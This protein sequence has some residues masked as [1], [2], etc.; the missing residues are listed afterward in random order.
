M[1]LYF[2][3]IKT[4]PFKLSLTLLL[5]GASL[6]GFAQNRTT[7]QARPSA[8]SQGYRLL[9]DDLRCGA[10]VWAPQQARISPGGVEGPYRGSPTG[11]PCYPSLRY[12][13]ET[14]FIAIN[15][16]AR[17]ESEQSSTYQD[18][19]R[20]QAILRAAEEGATSDSSWYSAPRNGET[21]LQSHAN[22]EA[23]DQSE[24]LKNSK[25]RDF[26]LHNFHTLYIDARGAKYFGSDQMKAALGKNKDFWKL[27]VRI[28]DDRRVADVVLKIGYT[29]AWDFPFELTHQNTTIVLLSGKGEGP[30]SGPLGA[31]DVARNFVN[32]AKP[33]R[34]E[35]KA[36]EKSHH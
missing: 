26:I 28:V 7:T 36:E 33:W 12:P 8:A 34:E 19:V 35:K 5:F 25:D 1:R 15:D 22:P 14:N 10:Q 30:F 29:F 16:A 27:N 2:Q 9:T 3:N 13:G 4:V 20:R 17:R 18:L 23:P 31:A 11:S 21:E 6:T 32:M 24:L